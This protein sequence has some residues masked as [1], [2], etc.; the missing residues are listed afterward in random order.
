MVAEGRVPAA[1]VIEAFDEVDDRSARLVVSFERGAVDQLTLERGEEAHTR[2]W[3]RSSRTWR[4]RSSRRLIPSTAG[5][6]LAGIA[7]RT[8]SRCTGSL[9]RSDGPRPWAI[10]AGWP[11]RAPPSRATSADVLPWPTQRSCGST[12]PAQRP[13]RGSPPTSERT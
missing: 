9:D 1:R 7:C 4:C 5:L 6:P 11:Y 2:A 8:R 12:R 3:R 13:D 10:A